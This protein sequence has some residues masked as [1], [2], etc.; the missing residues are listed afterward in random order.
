KGEGV[1]KDLDKGFELYRE[2][3]RIEKADAD[4]LIGNLYFF[5]DVVEQDY[6]KAKLHFERAIDNKQLTAANNLG[7]MYRLGTGVPQDI[8]KAISLYEVS[9][10]WG[11]IIA[12]VNLSEIYL[13]GEG[14]AVNEKLGLSWLTKAAELGQNDAQYA[15]GKR[16]I[17]N[18]DQVE[19]DKWI[20]QSAELGNEKALKYL[21]RSL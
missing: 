19:G 16:L 9:I 18:Q 20:K 12:M 7:E 1:A 3:A 17:G 6:K 13:N 5:G 10:D 11:G 2:Y 15:L 21:N 14:V 8:H 4:A